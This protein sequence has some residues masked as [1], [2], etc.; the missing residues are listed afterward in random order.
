MEGDTLQLR[1]T[2]RRREVLV[3]ALALLSG[4]I[5]GFVLW[6]AA[7]LTWQVWPQLQSAPGVRVLAYVV[8]MAGLVVRA[9]D[10]DPPLPD[11]AEAVARFSGGRVV[12]SAGSAGSGPG[13]HRS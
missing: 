8:A 7:H 12:L 10:V 5:A 6:R 11:V 9:S 13:T 3:Y 1:R 2:I 4:G